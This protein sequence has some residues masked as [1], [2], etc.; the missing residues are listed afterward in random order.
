MYKPNLT[1]VQIVLDERYRVESLLGSGA[2]GSVYLAYD[3]MI[4]R[5]VAIKVLSGP[6]VNLW[7]QEVKDRFQR[8]AKVLSQLDHPHIVKIFSIGLLASGQ[9][10]LVMDC[11]PGESL[12]TLIARRGTLSCA[13]ATVICRQVCLAIAYAHGQGVIHRDI[14]PQNIMVGLQDQA[15]HATVLDF[16]M[17]MLCVTGDR[18]QTKITVTGAILGTPAYMSPEQCRGEILDERSDIYSLACVYFELLGGCPPF[19]A[20]EAAAAMWRQLKAPIPNLATLDRGAGFPSCLQT[21]FARALAKNREDRYPSMAAFADD[22]NE[23]GLAQ[24]Q[25]KAD[26]QKVFAN[27]GRGARAFEKGGQISRQWWWALPVVATAAALVMVLSIL[28]DDGNGRMSRFLGAHLPPATAGDWFV[29]EAQAKFHLQGLPAAAASAHGV[30][31]SQAVLS[32]PDSQRFSLGCRYY[33]TLG[34]A[35]NIDAGFPLVG[36]VLRDAV[37]CTLQNSPVTQQDEDTLISMARCL[38]NSPLSESQWGDVFAR[39]NTSRDAFTRILDRRPLL[40]AA[41][42]ELSG[43]SKLK[44]PGFNDELADRVKDAM[45]NYLDAALVYERGP[46]RAEFERLSQAVVALGLKYHIIGGRMAD[47]YAM[48]TRQYLFLHQWAKARAEYRKAAA[49]D[50]HLLSGAELNQVL[51]LEAVFAH[52]D[53]SDGSD[54]SAP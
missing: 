46:N 48:R 38:L 19:P 34:L 53:G 47:V 15:L 7:D 20:S 25:A 6:S 43:V 5:N 52:G 35:D 17:S 3:Q 2:Y 29:A 18:L 21:V 16:G 28:W 44:A 24:C 23:S 42:E 30:L 9:P 27:L 31:N 14:K 37:L 40:F 39:L 45:H 13:E 51:D 41:M 11:L 33:R 10:F 54:R 22:L 50:R 8:E 26:R 1:A 12:E 36:D 4:G 49:I 32:W